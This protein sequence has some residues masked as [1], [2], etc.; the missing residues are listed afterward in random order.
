MIHNSDVFVPGINHQLLWYSTLQWK[1]NQNSTIFIQENAF[2]NVVCK[3]AAI[4]SRG[5]WVNVFYVLVDGVLYPSAVVISAIYLF[6]FCKDAPWGTFAQVTD[7][8]L[9]GHHGRTV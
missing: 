4:L 6:L 8:H 1:F 5:R 9:T 3:M 2:E 7:I